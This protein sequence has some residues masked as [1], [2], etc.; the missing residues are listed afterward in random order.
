MSHRSL[1]P[2]SNIPILRCRRHR[3]SH[4]RCNRAKS[5]P[6]PPPTLRMNLNCKEKGVRAWGAVV[7]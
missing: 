6:P 7:G 4:R 1:C 3:H 5:P 2:R